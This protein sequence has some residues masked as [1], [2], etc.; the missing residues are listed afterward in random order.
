MLAVIGE[1]NV[2]EPR[3]AK[4]LPQDVHE[5]FGE[6]VRPGVQG[7]ALG[8]DHELVATEPAD[9]VAR[10]HHTHVT[11]GDGLQQLVPGDVPER[12]VDDLEVVEIDVERADETTVSLGPEQ[13]LLGTVEDERP[14][15]QARQGVV[16]RLVAELLLGAIAELLGFLLPR[17]VED[18]AVDPQRQPLA[19]DDDAAVL[20]H[21]LGGAVRVQ[22]PVLE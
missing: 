16:S 8:Q 1:R 20:R 22:D 13:H 14:I 6:H 17:Q 9:R 11:G 15:G 10:P 5:P 2:L 12:V 4:R 21:P 3:N 18:D 19:A 7:D